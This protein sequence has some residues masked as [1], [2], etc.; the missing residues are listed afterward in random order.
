MT[1]KSKSPSLKKLKRSIRKLRKSLKEQRGGGDK[2]KVLLS[3]GEL[4]VEKTDLENLSKI[5]KEGPLTE[6]L[7]EDSTTIS[8]PVISVKNFDQLVTFIGLHPTGEIETIKKPLTS[9]N[10]KENNVNEK[11]VDFIEA[12][13]K[14]GISGSGKDTYIK[15]ID[16]LNRFLEAADFIGFSS[17][18]ELGAAQSASVLKTKTEVHCTLQ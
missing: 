1:R 2:I 16:N 14:D 12:V 7:A 4:D 17:A 11:D 8:L 10:L 13:M 5:S 15:W 9:S 3:D 18:I 6:M